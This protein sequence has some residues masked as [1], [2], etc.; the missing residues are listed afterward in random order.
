M[1]DRQITK[2]ELEKLKKETQEVFGEFDREME[3]VSELL[4][5]DN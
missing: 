3:K 2:E 1:S 5:K 4:E